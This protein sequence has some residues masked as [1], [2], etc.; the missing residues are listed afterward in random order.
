MSKTVKSIII[1]VL[2]A[3]LGIGAYFLITYL[4]KASKKISTHEFESLIKPYVEDENNG[5]GDGNLV[6]S[7][8]QATGDKKPIVKVVFY[9]YN[10]YGYT[11]VK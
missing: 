1:V 8:P 2:V 6:V 11:D 10:V 3:V 9:G 4:D 5:N 7:V